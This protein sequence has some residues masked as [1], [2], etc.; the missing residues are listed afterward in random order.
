M[1]KKKAREV[2]AGLEFKL[3]TRANME[4][5]VSV[6]DAAASS[7]ASGGLNGSFRCHSRRVTESDL[8]MS[9]SYRGLGGLIDATTF[10]IVGERNGEESVIRLDLG[11]YTYQKGALPGMRPTIAG[12]KQLERLRSILTTELSRTGP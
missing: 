9:W 2:A 10:T 8:A 12:G 6:I 1:S 7:S 11:E 5:V 4:E 3:R